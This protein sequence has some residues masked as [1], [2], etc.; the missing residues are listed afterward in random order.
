MHRESIVDGEIYVGA[1]FFTINMI[2]F[3][4]MPEIAMTIGRLSVFYKQRDHRFYPAWSYAIP[5]WLIKGPLTLVEV[6]VWVCLTYYVI[7]FDS[8]IVR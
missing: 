6:A 3:N 2:M 5:T 8:N 4:G 1:L 7:G